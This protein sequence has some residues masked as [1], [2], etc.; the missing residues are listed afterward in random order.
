MSQ[1]YFTVTVDLS[2]QT[3]N[4]N[5]RLRISGPSKIDYNIDFNLKQIFKP[6]CDVW[7]QTFFTDISC[8]MTQRV[9]KL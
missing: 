6:S 8:M 3:V 9:P 7:P 4:I 5:Q 1:F 2:R